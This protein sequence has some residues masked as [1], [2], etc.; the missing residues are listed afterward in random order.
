MRED[1]G[2]GAVDAGDGLAVEEGDG[3]DGCG[4]LL[5]RDGEDKGR[6]L[7]GAVGRVSGVGGGEV[8]RPAGSLVVGRVAMLAARVDGAQG[9][10]RVGRGVEEGDGAGGWGRGGHGSGEL[11]G[12]VGD[13]GRGGE[14]E[15]SGSGE[16]EAGDGLDGGCWR[17]GGCELADALVAG[18]GEGEDG[19][20]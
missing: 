13:D 5:G 4:E 8:W 3:R 15:G 9:G 14:G 1:A 18:V 19:G 16:A 6:A 17:R 11:A 7:G 20:G 2:E 10:S 12:A